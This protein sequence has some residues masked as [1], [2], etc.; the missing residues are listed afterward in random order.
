MWTVWLACSSEV[1]LPLVEGYRGGAG[2]WPENSRA[3]VEGAA[4]MALDGVHLDLALTADAA[5]VVFRGETLDPGR[6]TTVGGAPIPEGVRIDALTAD[7]LVAGYVCGGAPD[8]DFINALVRA[9]APVSL[10][11]AVAVLRG[12]HR[13]HVRL[14]VATVELLDAAH[15][16]WT[17]LDP[18]N[19]LVISSG[20]L[21]VLEAA[22]ALFHADA[23]SVVTAWSVADASDALGADID[24]VVL[25]FARADS[26]AVSTLADAGVAVWAESTFGV[27][28]D[29]WPDVTVMV[30]PYPGDAPPGD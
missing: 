26:D 4:K 13:T 19:E 9:E 17:D 16:V 14:D 28:P 18:P 25:P 8:P 6:C 30:T 12:S 21:A 2:Y 15:A 24:A 23:R 3:A 10:A 5:P 29:E 7:A 11:A 1:S 27:A 22:Q 20:S